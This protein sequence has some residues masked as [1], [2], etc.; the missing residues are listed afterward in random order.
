MRRDCLAFQ[1]RFVFYQLLPSKERMG[2]KE[3]AMSQ[4][5]KMELLTIL[6]LL[7]ESVLVLML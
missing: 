4:L 6:S 5:L 1:K 2:N 3:D 7:S